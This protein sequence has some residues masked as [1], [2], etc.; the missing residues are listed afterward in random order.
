MK[1][2]MNEIPIREIFK[3]YI[4]SEE[5]GIVA[6]SGLLNIRPAFQR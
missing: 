3:G 1:I 6:Y 2:E 5:N 4:D